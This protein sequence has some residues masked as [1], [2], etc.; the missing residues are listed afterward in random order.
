MNESNQQQPANQGILEDDFL[1]H[2]AN[3]T[4]KDRDPDQAKPPL[5]PGQ[6]KPKDDDPDD[7][8]LELLDDPAL[9]SDLAIETVD[10][11]HNIG[12]QYISGEVNQSLFAVPES[13]KKRIK[14][15]LSKVVARYK[16]NMNPIV[17]LIILILIVYIP[18]T[19]TAFEIRKKKN[20]LAAAKKKAAAGSG[21]TTAN[22]QPVKRKKPGRPK[23]STKEVMKIKRDLNSKK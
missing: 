5:D 10:L 11:V 9:I 17:V 3:A 18:P 7:A 16:W 20:D 12:M 6:A 8:A 22:H 15:A 23:G 2:L 13:N 14:A 4:E 1:K 21:S 19:M